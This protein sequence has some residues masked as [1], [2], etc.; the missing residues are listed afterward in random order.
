MGFVLDA[1][2]PGRAATREQLM[3]AERAARGGATKA[4]QLNGYVNTSPSQG[5]IRISWRWRHERTW[6]HGFV[7][8]RDEADELV[9]ELRAAI[10]RGEDP[11]PLP[12]YKPRGEAE[13]VR[14]PEEIEEARARIRAIMRDDAE[15]C[16]TCGMLKPCSPCL[17]ELRQMQ[18]GA[19]RSL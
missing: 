16:P 1:T 5:Y 11:V 3:N 4:K 10:A 18:R 14:T 9:R 15:R 2:V 8:T 13:H 6:H 17:P 7:E 12:Q 19:R